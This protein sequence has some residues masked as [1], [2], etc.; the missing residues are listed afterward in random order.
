MMAAG[1]R[2]VTKRERQETVAGSTSRA[3]SLK[4]GFPGVSGDFTSL[5]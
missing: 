3:L 1:K 2:E 5:L 4:A